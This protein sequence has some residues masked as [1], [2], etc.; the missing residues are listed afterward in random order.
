VHDHKQHQQQQEQQQQ[1]QNLELERHLAS[2]SLTGKD[3]NH[4]QATGAEAQWFDS[5]G[6]SDDDDE[7][8]PWNDLEEQ[9]A[10]ERIW[11]GARAQLVPSKRW[12]TDF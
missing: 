9:L 8:M 7:P 4:R 6:K 10:R 1:Q 3:L 11:L 5:F 2:L 12:S